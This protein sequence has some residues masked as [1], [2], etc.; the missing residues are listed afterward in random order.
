MPPIETVVTSG[1]GG[2]Y[3]Y[4]W[5]FASFW[6][7]GSLLKR[8]DNSGANNKAYLS[9]SLTDFIAA[10]V[11]TG[12]VLYNLTDGSLGDV[13][14]VGQHTLTATLTGGTDNDWDSGDVYRI[15]LI[16]AHT[17]ATIAQVLEIAASD[18]HAVL[19]A[20]GACSCTWASWASKFLKKLNIIEAAAFYSCP[21]AKPSMTEEMR[22]N[23]LGWGERQLELLRTGKLEVCAGSTG[24]DFPALDWAEQSVTD[25]AAAQIID[26]AE[27]RSS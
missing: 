10:G 24:A 13:T 17:I 7:V 25:F 22:Q 2:S 1:C 6:C 21:C 15:V 20:V 12:M 14:V 11:E 19:G 18:I 9:D 16:D 3:A 5:E 26:N 23:L 4:A 8:S 27:D